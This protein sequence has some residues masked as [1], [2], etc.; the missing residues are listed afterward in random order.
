MI[1][2]SDLNH[3]NCMLNFAILICLNKLS[4]KNIILNLITYLCFSGLTIK[5]DY[6]C[7]SNA[8]ISF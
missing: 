2:L 3:K 6:F 5:I 8:T 7:H 1:I 4:T